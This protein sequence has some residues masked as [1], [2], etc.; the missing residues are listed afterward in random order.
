METRFQLQALILFFCPS[1]SSF[2]TEYI[3]SQYNFS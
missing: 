1:V 2:Y 3:V